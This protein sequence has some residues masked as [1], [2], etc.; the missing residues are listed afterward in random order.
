MFCREHK[1]YT[2]PLRNSSTFT[3]TNFM[4]LHAAALH[5]VHRFF[6]PLVGLNRLVFA[7]AGS[8]AEV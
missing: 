6:R 7:H 4:S 2:S 8:A 5:H 3:S 1:A